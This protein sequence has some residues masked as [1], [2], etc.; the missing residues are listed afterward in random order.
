MRRLP[1]LSKS[2]SKVE[3]YDFHEALALIANPATKPYIRAFKYSELFCAMHFA[4]PLQKDSATE[5]YGEKYVVPVYATPLNNLRLFV[6]VKLLEKIAR[7][8]R[9][10]KRNPVL[11]VVQVAFF[12]IYELFDCF[13]GWKRTVGLGRKERPLMRRLEE[14]GEKLDTV[15]VIIDYQM[16]AS[17]AGVSSAIE[18]LATD[19]YITQFNHKNI[20]ARTMWN[21]WKGAGRLIA[22]LSYLHRFQAHGPELDWD[23]RDFA[24]KLTKWAENGKNAEALVLAYNKVCRRLDPLS[25]EYP[26]VTFADGDPIA[27]AGGGLIIKPLPPPAPLAGS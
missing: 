10:R 13:G 26:V 27:S 20:S 4:V 3:R 19:R 12:E 1:P 9:N 2:Y 8:K 16:R 24:R 14:E 15:A 18:A 7:G 11:Q 22:V 21:R 5:S 6:T 23:Q 25:H 17:K